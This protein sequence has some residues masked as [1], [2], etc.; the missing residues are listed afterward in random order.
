MSG[1]WSATFV[2]GVMGEMLC[3]PHV[4][5]AA[6]QVE[7]MR[8]QPVHE[9]ARRVAAVVGVVHDAKPDRCGGEPQ[10][11]R[12]RDHRDGEAATSSRNRYDA[13]AQATTRADF[14]HITRYA[15]RIVRGSPS[16]DLCALVEQAGELAGAL[17]A[18]AHGRRSSKMTQ[19]LATVGKCEST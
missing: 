6:D 17:E 16:T 4:R 12:A 13:T 2:I 11:E 18:D 5:R 7:R 14:A 1:S 15:R 19:R 10:R 9:P 8:R 3:R